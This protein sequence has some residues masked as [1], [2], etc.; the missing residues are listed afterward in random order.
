MGIEHRV[1]DP[2]LSPHNW[3]NYKKHKSNKTAAEGFLRWKNDP[4]SEIPLDKKA[5]D[6]IYIL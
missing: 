4:K 1:Q 6:L 5:V 2:L 3:C